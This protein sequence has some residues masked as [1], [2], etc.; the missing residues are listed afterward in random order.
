MRKFKKTYKHTKRKAVITVALKLKNKEFRLK[1]M[2]K[3]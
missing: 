3:K 2:V 1:M